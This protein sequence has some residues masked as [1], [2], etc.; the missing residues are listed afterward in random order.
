VAW[1]VT[2]SDLYNIWNIDSS[3]NFVSNYLGNL[4]AA[5][6]ALQS[7]E[8]GFHQDLNG[9]GVIDISSTTIESVGSTSLVQAGGNYFFNP[10]GGGSGPQFKY[11]GAPVYAGEFGL[12]APIG[13]EQTA[14]GYQVAWKVTGS[15][16]YN[17]W[18]IDSSG[19]FVSNYLGNLTAASPALQSGEQSFHQD[20]NGDGV[21]GRQVAIQPLASAANS[22]DMTNAMLADTFWFR[23]ESVPVEIGATNPI[24]VGTYSELGNRLT[25]PSVEL[26]D[27]F[28]D[29]ASEQSILADLYWVHTSYVLNH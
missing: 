3:G 29:H 11:N 22:N 15:D 10:V 23:Q 26:L 20:L 7:F 14:S 1:K 17:I 8:P 25:V 18:N 9:N 13:V 24:S 28:Q 6:P 5:S 4:T 2:G 19:N 21:I 27:V 12:W 16:L